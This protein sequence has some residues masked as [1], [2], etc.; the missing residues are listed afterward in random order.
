MPNINN[1]VVLHKLRPN[2]VATIK[3][4]CIFG[5]SGN[6]VIIVT[7][8]DNVFAFG[9]NKYGCLGL[10][11]NNPIQEPTRL[12]ELCYKEIAS[13]AYCGYYVIA[14]TANGDIYSWGYNNNGELGI[15]TTVNSNRPNLIDGL[16]GK[17][18]VDISC[19]YDHSLAL[20]ATGD[21][22]SWGDNSYGQL[23][24]GNNFDIQSVPHKVKGFDSQEVIQ[25]SCGYYHSMAITKAGHVY[26]WG[27]NS[28]GEL[29]LGNDI[30]QTIPTKINIMNGVIINKVVCG[31]YHSLLLS[32][33]GDIYAFGCNQFGQIG[34]GNKMNQNFPYKIITGNKFSD[35]GSHPLSSISVAGSQTTGSCYVWG[36]CEPEAIT[37]PRETPLQSLHDIFSFYSKRKITYKPIHFDERPSVNPLVDC[38]RKAFN[39]IE[40]SD[41]RFKINNKF[42]YA[43]KAILRIRC[44]HFRSMFSEHWSEA[45]T[46]EIEINIF[47]YNVFYSFIK[48]IYTNTV[49]IRL[50]DAVE[51]YDL[52]NSYCEDDLKEKCAQI[53]KNQISVQ[54]AITL[55]ASAVKYN[56]QELETF[57]VKFA[58]NNLNDVC[59]T[60]AF[61]EIE[62]N[63][64]KR[65]M[66]TSAKFRAFK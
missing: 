59:M 19:G 50:D 1:W 41:F 5:E 8:D 24:N 65:F 40:S 39:E 52:A 45:E 7:K 63:L 25:I 21:V 2:F 4:V 20:T 28:E 42:I 18:I 32:T 46:S 60:T 61:D 58:A 35:I 48:Y 51:L 15:G 6:E 43:H 57:C 12:E 23:G 36:D 53:I 26:G 17:R 44:E 13:I 34:N 66:K 54:N 29:G 55:Y 10:G 11:H 3:L 14:F 9:Y 62:P 27:Y 22:Y 64:C 56:S 38:M 49:E 33:D 37:V 47:S 30:S 16:V 31:Q